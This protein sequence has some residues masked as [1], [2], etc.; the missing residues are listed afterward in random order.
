[1]EDFYRMIER[2]PG[3]RVGRDGSV[4]SQ[5]KRGNPNI[6]GRCAGSKYELGDTWIPL[7]LKPNRTGYPRASL[8]LDGKQT[9]VMVHLL[10]LEAFVGPRPEGLDG[11]H[12]NDIKTDCYLDNLKWGTPQQNWEDRKRNGLCKPAKG[13]GHGMAKLTIGQVIEIKKRKEEGESAATLAD[14]FKVSK[15]YIYGIVAGR[16]WSGAIA[17]NQK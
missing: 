17:E 11:L 9:K 13:E 7:I 6:D 12:E 10:V 15:G 16:S 14:E 1:M 8:Y 2:F 3:Y 4:W 5:R